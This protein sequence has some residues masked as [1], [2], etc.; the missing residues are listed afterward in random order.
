MKIRA[1]SQLWRRKPRQAPTTAA[2]SIAV[3]ELSWKIEKASSAA[4]DDRDDAAGQAVEPV[5]QVDA[6]W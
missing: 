6:R 5:D 3:P 4:G 1:G 2:K